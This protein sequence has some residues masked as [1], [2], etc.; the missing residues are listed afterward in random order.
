MKTSFN[1]Y[2]K[3]VSNCIQKGGTLLRSSRCESFHKKE[4]RQKIY[5]FLKSKNIEGLIVIGGNGSF[6]G[7][8]L[9]E[10]ES[11]LKVVGIP[12]TIDNDIIG[13]EYSLGFDTARNTALEA[14]DKIRDTAYSNNRYFLIEVM[15]HHA[16][17]LALDIGL[18]A[19]AEFIITPEFPITTENLAKQIKKPKRKKDSL[20]VI[21]AEGGE[22][23][24]TIKI[25]KQLKTLTPFEYRVCVL[26]HIQRGGSP[27][28]MD[29]N[30][31]SEMGYMATESLLE[32]KSCMIAMQENKLKQ[33]PFPT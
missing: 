2:T 23:G 30:I 10:T 31:G 7:A 9:I 5:E 27:S 25:A 21:I 19:G 20:I 32:E 29:R 24:Q 11:N 15:G 17:F 16:G 26:G 8:S 1:I 14:I 12:A 3:Q 13:T 18:A 4:I 28:A 22:P 33:I 6:K